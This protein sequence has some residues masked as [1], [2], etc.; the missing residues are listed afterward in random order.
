MSVKLLKPDLSHKNLLTEYKNEFIKNNEV[1]HG[2]A[3]LE[4]FSDFKEWLGY[5]RDNEDHMTVRDNRVPSETYIAVRLTDGKLVGMIDIRLELN[6]YLM[7]YGG[8]IGYSVRKE[9]RRRGYATEMLRQ[10]LSVCKAYGIERVLITCDKDNTGS[11]KTILHNGGE[12]EN[13]VTKEDGTITQR[14]WV[15]LS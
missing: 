8:H 6:E 4:Q 1:L 11:F 15:D 2:S 3:G 13:E 14:Y 10:A 9:F 12:L 7:Q 5:L